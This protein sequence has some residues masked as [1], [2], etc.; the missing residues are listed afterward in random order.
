MKI[1]IGILILLLLFTACS[2]EQKLP[3]E[4]T[5]MQEN[6]TIPAD[7]KRIYLAGG[8]FWGVEAYFEKLYGVLDVK[9]G[10]ANGKTENPS[11]EQVVYEDTGHAETVEIVYDPAKVDLPY[12]IS[13]YLRIVDPTSL[14]KQ[15]NDVG[16]QY[17]T[18]IYYDD[19]EDEA[20][21]KKLLEKAQEL[22]GMKYVIELEPLEQF[23]D[24]EDYHQDY[25]TKNPR[26][27][28]HV[29]LL[30][31]DDLFVPILPYV[32]E[33]HEAAKQELDAETFAIACES[34]TERP[35]SSELNQQ[36]DP[37]IYVDVLSGEPLFFSHDKYDA[38]C[39]WPSFVKPIQ[40]NLMRYVEDRSFGMVR[41]EVRS[42]AGDIHLGHVFDDG[43]KDRGG[44]RF[45]I[46]GKVLRF[47]P[48]AEMDQQRYGYLKRYFE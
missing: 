48:L 11:Y 35:H 33:D 27:Y 41:V 46:N 18:G 45:C 22:D 44:R 13:Q 7:S 4:E 10:Y 26:G 47:V 28:C 1:I 32:L 15:G 31:A 40:E 8:C 12:L 25:L 2:A 17:R 39:G 43:P 34:G 16:T 38:G 20:I 23:F 36:Y 30:M 24:A 19:P 14:N 3:A 42:R 5:K 9:S 21:L 6:V 37:G 29:N